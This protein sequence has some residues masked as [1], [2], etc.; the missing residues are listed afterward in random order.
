[1]EVHFLTVAG[2]NVWSHSFHRE[3]AMATVV[4]ELCYNTAFQEGLVNLVH[5]G[6]LLPCSVMASL[7]QCIDEDVSEI[8]CIT[9]ESPADYDEIGKCDGCG[10]VRCVFHG[11]GR[12]TDMEWVHVVSLCREC[13]GSCWYEGVESDV[14]S[15]VSVNEDEVYVNE[16]EVYVNEDEMSV[17]EDEAVEVNRASE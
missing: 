12:G 9:L 6:K 5:K 17:N 15:E 7:G 13:G 4:E 16:D 3:T 8:T 11:Y 1:M 14:S 10:Q 2:E